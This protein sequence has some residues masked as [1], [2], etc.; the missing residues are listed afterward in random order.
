M[1]TI[2]STGENETGF[3][4]GNSDSYVTI[5]NTRRDRQLLSYSELCSRGLGLMDRCVLSD[6]TTENS[7]VEIEDEATDPSLFIE[8]PSRLRSEDDLL[9]SQMVSP[10][11]LLLPSL[12]EQG[13]SSAS[14]NG[15]AMD[16]SPLLHL[17]RNQVATTGLGVM[18]EAFT[19]GDRW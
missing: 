1:E 9:L 4:F 12:L 3:F 10:A 11:F 17:R 6:E 7:N 16:M 2:Y 18:N 5:P 14:E 15:F 8:V 19:Q 13:F